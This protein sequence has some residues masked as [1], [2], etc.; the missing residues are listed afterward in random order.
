MLILIT[1]HSKFISYIKFASHIMKLYIIFLMFLISSLHS[2]EAEGIRMAKVLT[3]SA[4]SNQEI[5]KISSM[6][7]TDELMSGVNRKL[8]TK[9]KDV[10]NEP[11]A[12]DV[13]VVD[14]TPARNKSP[15]H[16]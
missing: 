1:N 13:D 10:V 12:N 15:I 2:Y 9:T 16:N 7:N 8:M 14:Y 5:I 6:E 3:L 11:N 4:G